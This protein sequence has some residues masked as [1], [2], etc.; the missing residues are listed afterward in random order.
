MNSNGYDNVNH[1]TPWWHNNWNDSSVITVEIS[2]WFDN[3]K[4]K[5]KKIVKLNISNFKE[6]IDIKV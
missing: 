1:K 4:D 3:H 5:K 6:N 2:D